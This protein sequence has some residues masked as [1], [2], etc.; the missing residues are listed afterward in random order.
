MN[1]NP[2][3]SMSRTYQ[4]YANQV[5]EQAMHDPDVNGLDMNEVVEYSDEIAEMLVLD[6][7]R[8]RTEVERMAEIQIMSHF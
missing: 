2:S 4:Y 3:K 7:D 1:S 8:L 5:F 6:K